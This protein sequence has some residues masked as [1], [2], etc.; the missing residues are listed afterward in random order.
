MYFGEPSLTNFQGFGDDCSTVCHALQSLEKSAERLCSLAGPSA[1]RCITARQMV[2]RA[3]ERA[4]AGGCN[5]QAASPL[6]AAPQLI[7]IPS[8]PTSARRIARPRT[9]S[10]KRRDGRLGEYQPWRGRLLPM[11]P[12]KFLVLDGFLHNSSVLTDQIRDKVRYLAGLIDENWRRQR[13]IVEIRLVGHT[14]ETGNQEYNIGLGNRRAL[15]VQQELAR[16]GVTNRV[17]VVVDQSPGK[18]QRI[19]DDPTEQGRAQNRRVEVFVKFKSWETP[20]PICLDPTR[21]DVVR[22]PQG[23]VIETGPPPPYVRGIPPGPPGKSL[24]ERIDDILDRLPG[25]VAWVIRRAIIT[26]GCSGLEKVLG[27]IVGSLSQQ[28]IDVLHEGC[29]TYA[30]RKG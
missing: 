7:R 9:R 3:R 1:P 28:D 16:L 13:E 18:M 5:C 8:P 27:Q 4:I 10:P 21:C 14:D 6:S 29:A 12:L 2:M 19:V 26:G 25:K 22:P 15:S 11:T 24:N 30:Q 23:S 20:A 17:R